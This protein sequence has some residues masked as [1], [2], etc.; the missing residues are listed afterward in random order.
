MKRTENLYKELK[1][2]IENLVEF[3]VS[4]D[5]NAADINLEISEEFTLCNVKYKDSDD[6]KDE[7]LYL[8]GSSEKLKESYYEKLKLKE[9]G[10]NVHKK[11]E[12]SI[13]CSSSDK[14]EGLSETDS[15]EDASNKDVQKDE[16]TIVSDIASDVKLN[17]VI[18]NAES[19][20][21]DTKIENV[22]SV[23]VVE[24]EAN[25]DKSS[26]LKPEENSNDSASQDN[27]N[28]NNKDKS[29]Q[30]INFKEELSFQ[31]EVIL[32]VLKEYNLI[33]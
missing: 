9:S 17:D 5:L 33:S 21:K 15:S 32:S 24:N 2:K 18:N 12:D 4:N 31:K 29:K 7:F 20:T 19:S 13:T 11:E 6:I 25:E 27:A 26:K 8:Y 3:M 30:P 22:K 23:D 28:A 10:D 1:E 16:S 14:A